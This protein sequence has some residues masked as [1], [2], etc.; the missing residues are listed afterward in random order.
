[1]IPVHLYTPTYYNLLLVFVLMSALVCQMGKP[2]RGM[3]PSFVGLFKIFLV[4]VIL[5]V[6]LRPISGYYFGD[7][8]AYARLFEEMQ[9]SRILSPARNTEWIFYQY[10]DF[11]SQFMDVRE[12]FV[13]SATLYAGL[14]SLAFRLKHKNYAYIA[15]LMSVASFSF[16]AYGT[17]GLR[18][19]LATSIVL[20]GFACHERRWLASILFLLA[21]LTHNSM[22]IPV[23]AFML[24]LVSNRP[25]FYF[26]GYIIAIFLSLALGGWWESF[27]ANLGLMSDERI[28]YYL[29]TPFQEELFTHI[30]F[31]WD[32][33]LYSLAPI[34]IGSY[35][36]FKKN[37]RDEFYLRLFNTYIAAN[38]FWVLVIRSNYS[39]RIAYLSWFM[40][41]W[42]IIYPLLKHKM[43][44][45]QNSVVAGTLVTYFG[46]TYV[47]FLL[48]K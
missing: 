28:Q 24:T 25:K 34:A 44:S 20:L 22:V 8:A 38:S 33:L 3:L 4:F 1:M 9:T 7:T 2:K 13:L 16:W 45:R 6:G 14:A 32:F 21:I 35:F 43:F 23:V 29:I 36:I 18:N 30:G 17:N 12:W 19:G 15:F 41:S 26:I 48:G 47:L 39:N 5:F 40:M 31:R 46:F 42:V 10:M 27:F 37:Y 11:C